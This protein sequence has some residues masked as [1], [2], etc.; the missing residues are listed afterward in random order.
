VAESQGQAFLLRGGVVIDPQRGVNERMDLH[1]E[2]GLI[3]ACGRP[4]EIPSISGVESIDVTGRIVA[5]GLV[6]IHVHLR[7]P[8]EE[9]KE[10]IATGSTAAVAGGFTA[11]CCMPNTRPA[12]DSGS[13]TELILEK[14]RQ[15]NL[16]QVF[17]IGAITMGRKGEALAPMLELREAGCVAFSDD[18]SPVHDAQVMR[19]ALEYSSMLDRVLTVHEE[20]TSLSN[21]FS[22]N[23][24]ALSIALGLKGMPDA[25]E[26]VM[27]ARDIEL[28][29]LT[30]GY[31]HFCHVSTARGVELIRRAK[32]DGISVTAETAPHYMVATERAVAEYDTNAK[33]SMPLRSDADVEALRKGVRDGVIDCIASDHAPHEAD[34][35][36][37]EFDKATYGTLGLQTTLPLV[38]QCVREGA[39]SLERAIEALT[40]SARRCLKMEQQS[41]A[42]GQR[43]DLVVINPDQR[44]IATKEFFVSKSK[45][46][47]FLG[48]ELQ[49]HAERTFFGGR[50]VYTFRN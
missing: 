24:S 47:M 49:G 7:E 30:K 34:S 17:P 40:H 29:R 16:C 46:S 43:A 35:K 48:W 11:V 39:F 42:V 32:E 10:T 26:N 21:G 20:D 18:G 14:A 9:W 8:G 3:K 23:E 37:V 38:L 44:L 25:A 27:I 31:V 45:N 12:N 15:S 33:M 41:L 36:T 19:R 13:V 6:D 50:Q 22:M 2:N 1:V 28:A 5:P 4:G